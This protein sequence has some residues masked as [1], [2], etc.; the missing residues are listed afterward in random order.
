MTAVIVL[1][2]AN[3]DLTV[4][5]ERLP[6]PQ[7]TVTDGEFSATYGGKGANQALAALKAGAETR[8]IA[9]IGCDAFGERLFEHLTQSGLPRNCMLRDEDT[10]AGVALIGVDREGTNQIMVAPGS[11]RCLSPQDLNRLDNPFRGGSVFLCQ[12]ETPLETVRSGLEAAREAG[13]FT[14]LDPA[15]SRELPEAIYPLLDLITPNE[16]EATDLTGVRVDSPETAREASRI[17]QRRGCGA[18]LITLGG[19]GAL[20]CCG[21]EEERIPPYSV[22]TVDTVAAGDA[23]NGALAAALAEGSPIEQ[24]GLFAAAAAALSTTRAG[25]QDSLPDRKEIEALAHP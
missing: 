21:E 25:A 12:L 16:C 1:G 18:V 2:S 22:R 14:V 11:N 20:F 8:L 24:A 7:E 10:P 9:R 17:L 6:R 23:F 15:P 5:A 4:R 13:L 19:Q 3:T